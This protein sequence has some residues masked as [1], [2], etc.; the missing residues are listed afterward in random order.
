MCVW[1]V[2][3]HDAGSNESTLVRK[4]KVTY[5]GPDGIAHVSPCKISIGGEKVGEKG[6]SEG[7]HIQ[8]VSAPPPPEF[9]LFQRGGFTWQANMKLVEIDAGIE[10]NYERA[11]ERANNKK[12]G[13]GTQMKKWPAGLRVKVEWDD[14]TK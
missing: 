1:L 4:I 14:A 11:V 5:F 13:S 2:R 10:L 8:F 7:H 9:K 6:R 3:H 12:R